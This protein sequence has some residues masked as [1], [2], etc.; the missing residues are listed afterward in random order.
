[1]KLLRFLLIAEKYPYEPPVLQKKGDLASP[2]WKLRNSLK[3]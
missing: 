1:M 3:I 2:I